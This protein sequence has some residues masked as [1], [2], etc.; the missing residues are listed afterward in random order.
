MTTEPLDTPQTV[1]EAAADYEV[2]R[3]ARDA[4]GQRQADGGVDEGENEERDE[5][6]E[7]LADRRLALQERYRWALTADEALVHRRLLNA[8]RVAEARALVD[9]AERFFL[10]ACRTLPLMNQVELEAFEQA[11]DRDDGPRRYRV[12]A[13]ALRR[14]SREAEA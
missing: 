8:G 2:L 5:G 10:M 4:R 11:V 9:Q 6:A 12:V 7:L 3:P 13:S 1:R 14:L